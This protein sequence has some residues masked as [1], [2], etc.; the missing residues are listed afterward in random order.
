MKKEDNKAS[1]TRRHIL[2][3]KLFRNSGGYT[4]EKLITRL[5]VDL[6][7]YRKDEHLC[8]FNESAFRSFREQKRVRYLS[9]DELNRQCKN[10]L[11]D[12]Q[13]GFIL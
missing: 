13:R 5:N 9:Y 3:D 10:A 12:S 8:N 1:K 11:P 6:D 2:L 7:V 4:Y